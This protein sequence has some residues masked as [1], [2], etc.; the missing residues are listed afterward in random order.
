MALK[1]PEKRKA[2]NREY[3]AKWWGKPEN[4]AKKYAYFLEH[5]EA[6]YA[7][8]RRHVAAGKGKESRKA[9]KERYRQSE[10]GQQVAAQYLAKTEVR[11]KQAEYQAK[12]KSSP[13]FRASTPRRYH[14]RLVRQYGITLCDYHEMLA[15]QGGGCAICGS[16]EPGAHKGGHA[17]WFDVDHNHET[18]KVRGLL[19]SQCNKGLGHFR[20]S[21]DLLEKA[22]RYLDAHENPGIVASYIARQKAATAAAVQ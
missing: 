22:L 18:N 17:R 10:K 7:A 21:L 12:Y 1:D 19:C 20:D 4:R 6:C 15:A 3:A 13:K 11:A 9:A 2:Y 5:K 16:T 14:Q 8:V